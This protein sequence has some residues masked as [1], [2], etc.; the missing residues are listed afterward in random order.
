MPAKRSTEACRSCLL[1]NFI[2]CLR[3]VKLD[4][5]DNVSACLPGQNVSYESLLDFSCQPW[6]K[7]KFPGHISFR[8]E[9]ECDSLL[10]SCIDSLYH[11]AWLITD[12]KATCHS[13]AENAFSVDF[14][15]SQSKHELCT[16]ARYLASN[17]TRGITLPVFP[18]VRRP[19]CRCAHFHAGPAGFR[20]LRREMDGGQE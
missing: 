5:P 16:Q 19:L 9:I 14:S 13:R 3:E 10:E 6:A 15:G 2:V 7:R 4:K 18:P 11:S 8:A 20:R 12:K 17:N 1:V